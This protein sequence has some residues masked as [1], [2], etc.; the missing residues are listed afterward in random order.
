MNISRW[1]N[2]LQTRNGLA[3]EVLSKTKKTNKDARGKG[4]EFRFSTYKFQFLFRKKVNW[5]MAM[6]VVSQLFV[7]A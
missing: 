4:W 1:F 3:T 7:T 2:L 6:V 5:A